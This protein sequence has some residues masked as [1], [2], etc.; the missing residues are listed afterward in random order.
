MQVYL[1]THPIGLNGGPTPFKYFGYSKNAKKR[2]YSSDNNA[3]GKHI[4]QY[5]S[6]YSTEILL[7]TDNQFDLTL[8][9]INYSLEH[10]IWN[11]NDFANLMMENG[12]EGSTKKKFWS[13]NHASLTDAPM[14]KARATKERNGTT[15]SN[16]PESLAKCKE[17]K[18]TKG[19]FYR[20]PTP[21]DIAKCKETKRLN[22]TDMSNPDI[23]HKAIETRRINGTM[24]N[25]TPESIAKGLAT[26][27]ARYGTVSTTTPESIKLAL[28]TKMENGNWYN[29]TS[30]SRIKMSKAH[31]GTVG[32]R[33]LRDGSRYRI[34]SE[35]FH[36]HE[37][38]VGPN[39]K[40]DNY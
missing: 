22:N 12:L 1:R 36:K 16:T 31:K 20:T 32:C 23:W 38:L 10:G 24:N 39:S 15:N 6:N 21:N 17:T 3:W 25:S 30:E 34:N 13:T 9:C 7:E 37:Y 33:D 14:I 11:N 2:D 5:G 8:F 19:T 4:K 29:A 18:L 27:V 35:E 40:V 26:R 28:T